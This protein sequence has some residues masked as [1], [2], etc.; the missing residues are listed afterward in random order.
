M[1]DQDCLTVADKAAADALPSA[2]RI[3]RAAND[4]Y[5]EN[6]V[7]PLR[8]GTVAEQANV[9][10]ALIYSHFHD[11]YEL[12]HSLLLSHLS[13]IDPAISAAMSSET[14]FSALAHALAGT[15]FDHY[16]AHGLILANATQDDFL[17]H[18][19]PAQLASR[20]SSGLK[21][22]AQH[23]RKAYGF[24][25]REAI[26]AIILLA[27]IPEQSARLVRMGRI[28]EDVG[29]AGVARGIR[30]AVHTFRQS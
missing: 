23:A 15:L 21:N 18:K 19:L 8:L 9:S 28:S 4:A 12:V 1:V 30:L 7:L 3:L 16:I 29:R 26:A 5:N 20:L 13:L 14:D 10:R 27:V 22:L 17:N 6:A 25:R 11:Q 24:E 2:T